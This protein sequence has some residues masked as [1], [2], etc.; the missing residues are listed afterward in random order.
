MG[1]ISE[2]I[3]NPVFLW[4]ICILAGSG[5]ILWIVS[6][7]VASN[8]VFNSTLRRKSKD[9]WSREM[10]KDIDPEQIPMYEA[11]VNWS[12]QHKDKKQLKTDKIGL[13]FHISSFLWRKISTAT[14]PAEPM[15]C[16]LS[17]VTVTA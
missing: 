2:I 8:L 10:P 3:L 16:G 5:I 4:V 6:Y 14:L 9:K 1:I 11:G 13:V 7:F 15:A 17:T 12:E